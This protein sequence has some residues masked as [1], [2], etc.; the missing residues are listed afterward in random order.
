MN[1]ATPGMGHNQP[2]AIERA[3]DLVANCNRWMAERPEITDA[4]IAGLAQGFVDQL[5]GLTREVEA[6]QKAERE[7]FDLALV[8]IRA[9]YREPLELLGIALD[10]MKT[11][12][13]DW[14]DREKARHA[15]EAEDRRRAADAAIV[16][17][18]VAQT[19][20][21]KPG[22]TVEAALAARRAQD[23]AEAAVAAAAK[24]A[25]RAQIRGDYS[26]RAMSLHAKWFAVIDDEQKALRHFARH[27]AIRAAALAA[28][29]KVASKHARDCKDPTQAPP[30]VRFETKEQAV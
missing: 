27:P 18:A 7:P 2:P 8:V 24:P 29:V 19:E 9:K 26:A 22:A 28:I 16:A 21:E 17:A 13:E 14:L 30:G 5:R 25:E 20:A 23:L 1:D 3:G 4:E 6:E 10:K 11:L 15:R 12:A